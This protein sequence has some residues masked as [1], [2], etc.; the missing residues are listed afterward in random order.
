MAP[1]G[2]RGDPRATHPDSWDAVLFDLDGTLADTT[3]LILRSFRH[4]TLTHLGQEGRDSEWLA[5]MGMPL[6]VQMRDF[7]R[8]V[9]EAEAMVDTYRTFQRTIHDEMVGVFP[10]ALEVVERLK[11]RGTRVAVVTSKAREMALRT[12]LCCGMG[13]AFEVVVTYD[14]VENGK[15]HPESVHLALDRLGIERSE[16]V[17]F[18]GDSPYDAVAGRAAGVYTAAALWGPFTRARL[19]EVPPH[20][21]LE[22]LAELLRLS[23]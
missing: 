17:V 5:T 15:P 20:Y 1:L 12:L 18:L 7:A 22:S 16:R 14:D 23:P 8:S 11:E 9:E 13:D 2:R 19:E 3:G 6:R 21:Y 4:A 10:D